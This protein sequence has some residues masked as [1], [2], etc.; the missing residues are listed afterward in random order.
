M[1]SKSKEMC[2]G[3]AVRVCERAENFKGPLMRG[4][5]FVGS[6][7]YSF[8]V[9]CSSHLHD[10]KTDAQ[11]P[12]REDQINCRR[13]ALCVIA[14]EVVIEDERKRDAQDQDFD[15]RGAVV[16][17]ANLQGSRT[18]VEPGVDCHLLLIPVWFIVKLR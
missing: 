17:V 18:V 6:C 10:K 2:L 4:G 8:A 12:D 3:L 16:V 14:T 5:N 15:Q 7:R 1:D 13:F 9:A 11:K